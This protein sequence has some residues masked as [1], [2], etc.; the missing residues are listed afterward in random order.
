MENINQL[1]VLQHLINTSYLQN[2]VNPS[3]PLYVIK[4]SLPVGEIA[5]K[6]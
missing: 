1:K 3:F 2:Y 5:T 4:N 6:I